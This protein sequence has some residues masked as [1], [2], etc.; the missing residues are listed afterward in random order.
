[1]GFFCNELVVVVENGGGLSMRVFFIKAP[2][3][4]RIEDK[5]TN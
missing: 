3:S 4:L 2:T 5:K 1:M